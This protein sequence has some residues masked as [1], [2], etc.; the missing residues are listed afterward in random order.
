[1]TTIHRPESSPFRTALT[2]NA[3]MIFLMGGLLLTACNGT[4]NPNTTPTSSVTAVMVTPA[5]GPLNIGETLQ[6]T[7]SVMGQGSYAPGVTWTTSDPEILTV[8]SSGLVTAKRTGAATVTA[9]SV[10]DSNKFAVVTVRVGTASLSVPVNINFQPAS[11]AVPA[12]FISDTGAAYSNARQY[13][14]T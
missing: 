7:A 9:T 8:S 6:L 12:G 1:M 10:T 2:R 4:S 11:S 3:S 13:R 5:P 14:W